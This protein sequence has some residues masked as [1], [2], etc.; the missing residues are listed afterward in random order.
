MKEF[1]APVLKWLEEKYP[2]TMILIRGDSGFATP[3]L[4]E[5]AE[6]Y[7]AHYVIRLKANQALKRYSED[8]M[9]DF[10]KLYVLGYE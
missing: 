10:Q 3:E 1:L 8:I 9:E 5:L 2:N 6:K 4:Y 7:G